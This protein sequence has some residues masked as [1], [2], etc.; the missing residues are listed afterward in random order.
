MVAK[1]NNIQEVERVSRQIISALKEADISPEQLETIQGWLID[2][3]NR[4]VKDTALWELFNETFRFDAV[5]N[6]KA[7]E[8]L[9]DIMERISHKRRYNWRRMS[10]GRKMLRVAAVVLPLIALSG[11]T[12][13][14]LDNRMGQ[15][16]RPNA[17]V[18]VAHTAGSDKIQEV[19]LPCGSD[20]K[21]EQGS[22]ITY[23]EDFSERRG[24]KFEGEAYFSVTKQDAAPFVVRTDAL[25]VVVRGTKFK[26][27]DRLG[28][29]HVV[30]SLLKGAV[31]VHAGQQMTRLTPRQE[32]VYDRSTGRFDIHEFD[33]AERGIQLETLLLNG[34]PIREAV[35]RIGMFLGVGISVEESV[36]YDI[37]IVTEIDETDSPEDVFRMLNSISRELRCEQTDGNAVIK[38]R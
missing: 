14:L 17:Y 7:Y 15:I 26:L 20:V 1:K 5:P 29:D 21:L 34:V 12:F 9:S 38:M 24:V 22:K 13:M 31:D 35:D 2:E 3:A 36:P 8:L 37:K 27:K 19:V 30:V 4:R 16:F 6:E 28:D 25:T 18:T 33:P 23:A 32:F 11:A 10:F